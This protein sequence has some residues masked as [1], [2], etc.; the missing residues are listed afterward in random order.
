MEYP[1][2]VNQQTN[3]GQWNPH[4]VYDLAAGQSVTVSLSNAAPSGYVV[5]ADAVQFG[6][7]YTPLA[8]IA[9]ARYVEDGTAISLP[10]ATVTAVFDGEFYVQDSTGAAGIKVIGGG[11]TQGDTVQVSG[12]LTTIDGE[13]AI[14]NATIR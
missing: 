5:I 14:T 4:G 3:G 9:I 2:T 6:L 12:T 8:D 7:A 13:R 10:S 1:L 11:V